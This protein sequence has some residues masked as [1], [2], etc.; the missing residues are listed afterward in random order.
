[1]VC[2]KVS[3][4][5]KYDLGKERIFVSGAQAIVRML[6]MQR[7]RDR[8]AGLNTAG[9]VSGYR[10]SPLAGLDHQLW[11]AG[12]QLSVADIVF[13]PGLNE[14]LAA[15]ACWG[16]QQT[17]LLGEGRHDGVFAL[18]YGKGAGVDR[19]GDVFRHAN[20]AGSSKHGGVLA[21]MG[22]DHLAESSSVVHAS[23]FAFVDAMVPIL[24]PVGLQELIDYGIYGYALSRFAGTWT[25]IKCA[26]D[27]IESTASV[28][29]T[30][31]RLK[32]V[33]PHIDMPPGGLNIRHEVNQL[34]QEERLHAYKRAAAAAFVRE[35]GLNRIIWSG[36][37]KPQLGI[38]TVG[39]SYL[40]VRQ[41]LAD[42]GI[43]EERAS[44]LGIRLFKIACPW[45]LDG[46]H[47]KDFARGLQTVIAV[48]EK[49]PLIEV[50][51]R[52]NLYGTRMQPTIIGKKDEYGDQLFA[53][54]GSLDPNHIAIAIGERVLKIIGPSDEIAAR[55]AR[56]HQLQARL[57]SIRDIA[58]RAPGFCSGCPHNT[59]TRLPEGAIAGGGIGC[60]FM[61]LWMDR[62]TVGFTTMGGEGAQWVGQAPFSRREHVFQNLGDGTYNHSGSLAL[63]FAIAAGVNV[64][65]K[66][67]YNDA[68]AM[69]GGQSHEGGLTVDMIA[70]QVRA[71]GVSRIAVVSDAPEKYDGT[72]RFPAG[73]TIQHR[74]DLDQ[75]QRSL[76][77]VKGVSVLIYDQTCAAEKRRRR[78]RGALADPD[79]RV[80]INEL[81]CEGCGDCGIKS[82]CASL[83]PLDTEFGRK[84]RIDQSSCNKDFSC[85][86]GFCPA[87]VTVHGA[88]VKKLGGTVGDAD[89]L[90]GVPE[91]CLFPL[92]HGWSGVING[93][94]GTGVVT[95]GAV[96]GMAA[97]LEGKG[98]GIIDMAGLAQK[99]GAVFSYLRIAHA[100]CDIKA[101]C[102]PAGKAD[103]V[104]GCDLVVSGSRKVLAAVCEG[105][106]L[107]LANMAEVMPGDFARSADF[108]LP[109]EQLKKA[110]RDAA[111]EARVHF[112]DA[113]R[114]ATVLFGNSIGANMF[115]LGMACQLGGLPVSVEAIEK[116]IALNGQ[117]VAMNIAAFRWGRRAA[118]DPQYVHGLVK[119]STPLAD[120]RTE[121]TLDEIIARRTAF[122]ADY[123]GRAYAERYRAR[124]LRLRAVEDK[125]VPGSTAVTQAAARNLFK[126]MAVKDE[127]EVARLYT[128]GSFRRQL[129]AE[130]ESFD[131]LEFHLAPPIFARQDA[132]GHLKKTRYGNWMIKGFSVLA[133]LKRLRGTAFDPFGR[134][135]ERR[136]ERRLLARYE[137]DLDLI[138]RV[139]APG[140]VRI[141]T[142]LASIP[143]LIRGFG[144]VKEENAG[145]AEQERLRLLDS[146]E[147]DHSDQIPTCGEREKSV[148][149]NRSSRVLHAN[150][151]E[152]QFN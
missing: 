14:E 33:L 81:V 110:I 29:V 102:V 44:A 149:K 70:E 60:H 136:M 118:H 105:H 130:F 11:K 134:T 89:P 23:E 56:L 87:F 137:A 31:E 150:S 138:E 119:C 97:H 1:M 38:I 75:V 86:N 62:G 78:K 26:K 104:L 65:Y 126:L 121:Q 98:S 125:I 4:G 15:T 132:D 91:A 58:G 3:L 57:A 72:V 114:T 108:S 124:I 12:K 143:F 99:G 148:A 53:P 55:V 107:F 152:L 16:S 127:Y 40:D 133:R 52:E 71:E 6:L 34:G 112:F 47:I 79:R 8:R 21:L 28:D 45:P 116:A 85:V 63:R 140:R 123:Q 51:L 37:R 131:R 109:V 35:N 64:T 76:Q 2:H 27:N 7:E 113:T 77:E 39:A 92:D 93:I 67:L 135:A 17:E 66:I 139:L 117:A 43:D 69:T 22:D 100:P 36:G 82:N 128:D 122:L 13:Q 80:I 19:T 96:L 50:Q 42:L 111:G 18:W 95:I 147:K 41:A 101:I 141:A 145:K 30:Q 103:L 90:A 5:D 74:N 146:L 59:S 84:R 83:Q 24:N 129:A 73:A 61:A 120:D 68:V 48:E 151:K 25:A 115:M 32:I 54:M 49:R 142:E 46:E 94:G 106:T 88:K 9:F 10:G 144:H 20:L